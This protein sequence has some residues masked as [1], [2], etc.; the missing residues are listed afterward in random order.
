MPFSS[1]SCDPRLPSPRAGGTAISAPAGALS[2]QCARRCW[3]NRA[4]GPQSF[5]LAG[6]QLSKTR[7]RLRKVE[8]A[9]RL[10]FSLPPKTLQPSPSKSSPLFPQQQHGGQC[11]LRDPQTLD[12][13][14]QDSTPPLVS[15]PQA[16]RTVIRAVCA[17]RSWEGRCPFSSHPAEAS[18]FRKCKA[19][20][21]FL[22]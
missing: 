21:A 2:S 7:T 6:H 8:G 3:G 16:H 5:V 20:T 1:I 14:S 15:F 13:P 22:D 18:E 19:L 10:V 17:L 12:A 11:Y 4:A 9:L